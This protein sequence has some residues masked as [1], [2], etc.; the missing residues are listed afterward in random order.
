LNPPNHPPG[1]AR[2]WD[3]TLSVFA[4]K[5]FRGEKKP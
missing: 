2:A 5:Q 3:I 4:I 1:Y